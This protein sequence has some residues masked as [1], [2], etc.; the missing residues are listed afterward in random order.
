MEQWNA[1]PGPD[2]SCQSKWAVLPCCRGYFL[3]WWHLVWSHGSNREWVGMRQLCLSCS[4]V[5]VVP[6]VRIGRPL[7]GVVLYFRMACPDSVQY[8]QFDSK[9]NMYIYAPGAGC[10]GD[11]KFVAPGDD[12]IFS[13]NTQ[14][15]QQSSPL[16]SEALVK[17]EMALGLTCPAEQSCPFQEPL[18]E[19]QLIELSHKNFLPETMKKERWAVKMCHEWRVHRHGLG[20]ESIPCDLDDRATITAGSL[21]H[22]LC[23]FITEI[24]KV[25]GDEFLGKT[26][27]DILVCIQFHLECY[28][29]CFKLL[30]DEA[31]H[32]IK[33]TLD[34]TMKAHVAAGIGI[35][36]KQAQVLS[37]TDEDYLWSL[38][39]PWQ[40]NSRP[41]S[42]YGGILHGEGLCFASWQRAQGSKSHSIQLSAGIPQRWWQWDLFAVH[43]R[44]RS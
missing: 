8:F 9:G 37:V 40:F 15:D 21:H 34:N 26:L 6:Q 5:I 30:N 7:I 1:W 28:G 14:W 44:H 36:V 31:F 27:Y 17:E 41:A 38:G 3:R 29:F 25:N 19:D 39:L 22:S 20:L 16:L 23:R 33:F 10:T 13:N 4:F 43:W 24:K 18:R 2:K 35:T 32:D 11:A 42:E 12:L